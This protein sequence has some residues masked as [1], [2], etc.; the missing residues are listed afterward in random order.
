MDLRKEYNRKEAP[1]SLHH[2]MCVI[3]TW[4]ITFDVEMNNLVK[5]VS[6]VFP[7]KD[8]CFVSNLYSLGVSYYIQPIQKGKQIKFLEGIISK[9]LWTCIKASIVR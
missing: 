4:A 1:F 5:A 6:L 8:V 2:K 7:V 9:I 3:V